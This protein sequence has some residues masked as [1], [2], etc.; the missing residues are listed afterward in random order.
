MMMMMMM[1]MM[2]TIMAME[3]TGGRRGGRLRTHWS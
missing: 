1:M 3:M 2:M